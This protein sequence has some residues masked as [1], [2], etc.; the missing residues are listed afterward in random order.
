MVAQFARVEDDLRAGRL[1]A[2]FAL[3]VPT[4]GAYYLQYRT[5]QPKCTR[6]RVFED[7]ILC[8]ARMI[9]QQA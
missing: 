4:R 1:V 7:W 5:D 3:R 8:E 9:E 6:I 2:L